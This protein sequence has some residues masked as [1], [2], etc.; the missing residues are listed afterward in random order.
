MPVLIQLGVDQDSY[1]VHVG[2][3]KLESY[4][5]WTDVVAAGH[6]PLHHQSTS[7]GIVQPRLLR[8][9]MQMRVKLSTFAGQGFVV[10]HFKVNKTIKEETKDNV[11]EVAE[12]MVEVSDFPKRLLTKMVVVAKVVVTR[13]VILIVGIKDH[14]HGGEGVVHAHDNQNNPVQV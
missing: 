3:V 10:L 12:E 4:V 7:H 5:S 8:N 11:A 1:E 14:L 9:T 2:G 6:D 13:I